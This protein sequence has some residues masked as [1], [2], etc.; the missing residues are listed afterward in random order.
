MIGIGIISAMDL[1]GI[2]NSANQR[3]LKKFEKIGNAVSE[4]EEKIDNNELNHAVSSPIENKNS[5]DIF[6]EYSK[7]NPCVDSWLASQNKCTDGCD[8]GKISFWSKAGNFVEGIAKTI[9]GG[10][11]AF[12]SD[13]K[14]VLKTAVVGAGLFVLASMP[15][16]GTAIAATIAVI[17][18]AK[19][20]G[21][22]VKTI[23]NG[24]KNAQA[25]DT[26]AEAKDAWEQIG[27]GAF[28][29]GLGV[30]AAAKGASKLEG[31]LDLPSD[32][33]CEV[34]NVTG[35]EIAA[36]AERSVLSLSNT[37]QDS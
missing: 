32:V 4:I 10:A 27:N 17:G 37:I 20:I 21:N 16:V 28:K 18:G 12:I 15:P 8:D 31:C 22:G 29:T 5:Q 9:V 14:K 36:A 33:V 26:D 19:L 24:V 3:L 35:E 30:A 11:K 34:P 2:K 23:F 13:P 6:F 1:Y 25:A 7:M